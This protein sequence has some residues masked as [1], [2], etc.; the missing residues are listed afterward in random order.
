VSLFADIT[1][2]SARSIT[3]PFLLALDATGAV[4]GFISGLGEFLGYGL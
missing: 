2:E 1:Y 4:V 3:G